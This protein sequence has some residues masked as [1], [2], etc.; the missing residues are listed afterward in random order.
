MRR[1]P[2]TKRRMPFTAKRATAP[3]RATIS[4][5][6]PICSAIRGS[7]RRLARSTRPHWPSPARSGTAVLE[8][9]I[10]GNLGTIDA[11]EGRTAEA[12][13]H[14][15]A[16]LSIARERSN[17][18]TQGYVHGYLGC[19]LPRSGTE[20]G[21]ARA[22][23]RRA[24]HGAGDGESAARGNHARE[25]GG[26]LGGRVP[27]GRGTGR[28]CEGRGGAPGGGRAGRARHAALRPRA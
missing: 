10:L 19:A 8:G 2:S 13:T 27:V 18:R 28:V 12:F 25:P 11:E 9:T 6:S 5:T 16:A 24:F 3:E 22:P 7:W 17:R 14:F 26:S 23:R 1:E 15:N 4:S 20:G 21:R